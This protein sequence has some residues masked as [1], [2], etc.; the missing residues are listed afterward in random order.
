M[1]R[2]Q[3]YMQQAIQNV[4]GM[5]SERK[6]TRDIYG[7]LCH[8]LP[9]LLRTNGLCQ[10]LAFIESKRCSAGDKSRAAAYQALKSHIAT[11]LGVLEET[12]LDR[13]RDAPIGTYLRETSLLLDAWVYYKRFAVSILG[14][15]AG[16][17]KDE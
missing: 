6:E 7:G 12:L 3:R 13:V 1:M 4:Q 17:G 11:T 5:C 14:V 2:Q 8:T 9:I 16:E 10:T 15:T